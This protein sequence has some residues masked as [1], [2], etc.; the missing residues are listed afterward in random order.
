MLTLTR[1]QREHHKIKLQCPGPRSR[2]VK[3]VELIPKQSLLKLVFISWRIR[4]NLKGNKIYPKG[5]EDVE[6]QYDL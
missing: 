5:P 2:S 4:Y 3:N 1:E 6:W